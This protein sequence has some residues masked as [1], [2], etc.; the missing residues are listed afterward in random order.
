MV[1]IQGGGAVEIPQLAPV[2]VVVGFGDES[3]HPRLDVLPP[4]E[5]HPIERF[6][7]GKVVGREPAVLLVLIDAPAAAGLEAIHHGIA[8]DAEFV[9]FALHDA[10]PPRPFR[11]RPPDVLPSVTIIRH[12]PRRPAKTNFSLEAARLSAGGGQGSTGRY[13]ERWVSRTAGCVRHPHHEDSVASFRLQIRSGSGAAEYRDLPSGRTVIGRQPSCDLVIQDSAASRQHAAIEITGDTV[14]LSDLGSRNGTSVNG[15][16]CSGTRT[17]AEGDV[18]G[19]G[20]TQLVL[21]MLGRADSV[22]E[23]STATI[24]PGGPAWTEGFQDTS[25]EG[26]SQSIVVSE[27][28]LPDSFPDDV[29]GAIGRAL[30]GSLSEEEV[31][32]KLLDGLFSIFPKADRGFVLL[33]EHDSERLLLR[34]K[35]FRTVV[36][37]GPPK[38]SRSV[39]E[40][41]VKS[42]RAVL[43]NDLLGDSRFDQA[44]SIMSGSMRSVMC[45]P[46]IR[47]AGGDVLGVVQLDAQ[48]SG[49]AF[50]QRDLGV[51]AGLAA[52]VA[53]S[54]ESAKAHDERVYQEKLKR[55]LEIAH[56]V[57]QGLLPSRVP[58]IEGYDIFHHYA[59]A[60]HVGG[61]YFK[62]VPL[63]GGRLACVVADVSGKGV[64]AALVTA[65][66]DGE[67]RFRLVSEPDAASAVAAINDAFCENGWDERFATFVVVILDPA[68][69]RARIVNAG[70]LPVYL[71][72]ADGKVTEVGPEQEG[73]PLGMMAG[74]SYRQTDVAIDPGTTMVLFTDGVNEAM[75]VEDRI[76]GLEKLCHVLAESCGS[77]GD[78]G[79]RILADV[80]RHSAGQVQTD[81]IC[82]VCVTRPL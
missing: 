29:A 20:A 47:R 65:F 28:E 14:A 27:V 3:R 7:E 66:L 57:Q 80:E 6:G 15:Q 43:S 62:Y 68:G 53:K 58:A 56:K 55:D 59:P 79:R 8:V 81:D 1:S 19:I 64:S 70:H 63:P 52:V 24:A 76:Y 61:D 54:V 41:V 30:G 50:S 12:H 31:L 26:D 51:L 78:I 9:R 46:I 39:L 44:Q 16:R 73:L 35:K 32:P 72:A 5:P 49:S 25:A 69:H 10:C 22:R 36:E 77:A 60:L 67:V 13:H 34:A 11:G 21:Q 4:H 48:E 75:D 42:R 33:C 45:V 37:T 71:R 74:W 82:L 40:S 38:L 23:D 18:I 17:L 2:P